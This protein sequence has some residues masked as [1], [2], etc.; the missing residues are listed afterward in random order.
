MKQKG[1][2]R[3]SSIM[4]IAMSASLAV[5]GTFALFT[6]ESKVDIAVTSGKV[7]LIANIDEDSV[8]TKQ[9]YDTEYTQGVDNMFEGEAT[10]GTEGLTLEKFV[11]GDGIKFNIVVKNE[12][13]VS[14]KYRTI[15]SCKNDNGLFE[16]LQVDI[17]NKEN[18]NGDEYVAK[19][20]LIEVGSQDI[21]V[22]VSIE[23][24][25]EAANEYQEKTCT[26]SYRV[27]AVQGNAPTYNQV[28]VGDVTEFTN[29]IKN[30]SEG[31][32]IDA[33][34]VTLTISNNE[35]FVV[36]GGGFTIK[37]ATLATTS[38]GGDYIISKEAAG[39]TIVFEDCTFT[40]SET[41][42]MIIGAEEDGADFVFNNCTFLG[43]VAP[44][45]VEKASGTSQFNNCTF[46]LG[47]A[48]IKMGFVNCM[49]GQHT[50]TACTFDYTGGNTSGSNQ[51][52]KWNAINSYSE[53]DNSYS[54]AVI[55]NGCT[56]INC[57]TQ[58]YGSNST[59]TIK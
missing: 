40:R 2:A 37:G 24:P 42:M 13:T 55:L 31:D 15:I 27:E 52:V 33:T 38:R 8:Q 21:I 1:K 3:A 30:A 4:A 22:P 19:W 49:G 26:I 48:F 57:G 25:E 9:L 43:A 29:A 39:Q 7:S 23:L 10:F 41:G 56:R 20:E 59:L 51:Y 50:F 14:V 44:N 46:K 34:G 32:M 36:S 12:S 45:F 5:G 6:S 53:S 58:K 11:P 54:T 17:D 28:K 16:G 35:H 47:N 18:F